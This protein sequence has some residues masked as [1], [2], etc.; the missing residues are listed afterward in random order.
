MKKQLIAVMLLITAT[1]TI[2]TGCKKDK[3]FTSNDGPGAISY[4]AR[5]AHSNQYSSEVAQKW[6]KMQLQIMKTT[7]GISNLAFVRPFAY[8]SVAMYESVLPGMPSYQT[9][10]GQLTDLPAMPAVTNNS[11][12]NWGSSANASMAKFL[13]LIYP[14]MS[15]ANVSSV[16]SL[17]N[18]F[19]A[20]YNLNSDAATIDRSVTFGRN[21]AQT[22]YDW[23][24]TDGNVHLNDPYT[25]PT[26]P[27]LWVPTPP[28]FSPAPLGPY[29]R[30][31]R[32]MVNGSGNNAQP[33]AP[34]AY[35][36]VPGSDFYNMVKQVYDVSQTLTQAQ[37]D[38]AMYYRDIPGLSTPG[39]YLSIVE[40]IL[41][42]EN[43]NLEIAAAAFAITGIT[44]YDASISSWQTKYTY[45]L[46]RPI[47]YIR[48]V[49]GHTTW[50]SLLT[51]P[52]HPEYSSAHGSLSSAAAVAL[53]SIFGDNHS[54]TDHSYDYLGFPARS[55]S[56][57]TAF[58]EDAGNSRLFAGIHYQ[59]SIDRSLVQGRTVAQNI[60]NTLVIKKP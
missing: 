34:P 14:T 50:N 11:T 35:S 32:V 25:V 53:A 6:M 13:K 18:V 56:S 1:L 38:Q 5:G 33:P 15:A 42:Q 12:Y 54:F 17:E 22:V 46:V 26:G 20:Q 7:T 27:G 47:T 55:F 39:H 10:V 3:D 30:N 28:A 4:E 59:L 24:L 8:S 21:V 19:S 9:L 58:G 2:Q 16:D 57:F 60:L 41:E 40:Q 44:V 48:G 51:T 36:E 23:S 43:S 37:I 29:W 49:L 31:L 52:G 45:N